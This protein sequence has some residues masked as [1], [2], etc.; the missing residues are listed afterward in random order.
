MTRLGYAFW[1]IAAIDAVLLL[2][3]AA[4]TLQS[5]AGQHDGGRELGL[6][7]FI[8][9]PGFVL[10]LAMLMFHFSPWLP[11]KGIALFIVLVPGLWFAKVKIEDR[12]IDREI[13]ANRAGTGY[14]DTEPM[15]QMG[16][17]V[18]RRDVATLMR[19]GA[20]VDV[21]TGGRDMTLLGLALS[22]PDARVSDGSEM[23][24]VRALLALGA[25]ADA[26]MHDACVRRDATLLETLLAAGG[27]P[28]LKIAGSVPLVFDTMS[29][30]TPQNFRLLAGKGLDLNT[31]YYDEPLPVQL[32]IYRRWDLL[33]IAIELGADTKLAR[34]DGRNVADELASQIDEETRAGHEI[35]ADLLGARAALVASRKKQ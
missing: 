15:R 29:S 23:P 20:T 16:A 21:N 5:S 18:V 7:F 19:I 4:M 9:L 11:V 6:F 1:T 12:I 3:L 8:M 13:A 32:A 35:P 28:N 31:K 34:P 25:H 24:V 14:F 10:A 22:G 2:V 30:I 33:A 17:A 26:G 27:N